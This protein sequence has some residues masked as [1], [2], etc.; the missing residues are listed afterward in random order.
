MAE[1]TKKRARQGSVRRLDKIEKSLQELS[2]N[3][4]DLDQYVVDL[5]DETIW[6]SNEIREGMDDS[7]DLESEGFE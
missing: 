1:W 3:W 5:V 7:V 4:G 6:K 2:Y